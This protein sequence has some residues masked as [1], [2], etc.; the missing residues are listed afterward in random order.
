MSHTKG[1]YC[2]EQ[3]KIL[4]IYKDEIFSKATQ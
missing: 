1:L 3:L 4:K 2:F